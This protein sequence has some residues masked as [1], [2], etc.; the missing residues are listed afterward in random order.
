MDLQNGC[1]Y[2]FHAPK[3]GNIPQPAPFSRML[4]FERSAERAFETPA[5]AAYTHRVPTARASDSSGRLWIEEGDLKTG[6]VATVAPI[7]PIDETYTFRIPPELV[8]RIEAG[9]RLNVPLGKRNRLA[10]AF[11]V[12][13]DEG[14]WDS[15]LKAIDSVVDER[16]FLTPELLALGQWISRYYACPLGRTLSAMVP[17][18]VRKQAGYRD[19]QLVRLT[20]PL[21]EI[22]ATSARIGPKQRAILRRLAEGVEPIDRAHLLADAGASPATL[23]SLQ[24]RAWITIEHQRQ[25]RSAP[26]FDLP[27]R[28][29]EFELNEDQESALVRIKEMIT[30]GPF[31]V[32]LLFGV[33]GSGKTE[34]YIRAMRHVLEAGRQVIML[35]PEIALTTQ[36]VQRLASRFENVAV[37]HSGLTGV[38]RSLTWAAIRSG[39]KRVVIGTRSA[40]FAPCPNLGLIVV[41]EEQDASY[42]NLQAPRFHVR[43]VAIKR[44]QARSI[45][46]ILGS[47]TPSLE[48]WHNCSRRSDYVRIDLPRRVRNLPMPKVTVVDMNDEY[49]E[50]RGFTVLSRL[51]ERRLRETLDRG[52]QAV[53]LMNRRG[54]ANWLFCP[55]CKLRV[56]CPNCNV[57][58][59]VH[60][61]RRQVV[62][63]Y[64]SRREAVPERCPN[65]SCGGTLVQFGTGTQRVEE[66]LRQV[67]PNVRLMRVDSDTMRHEREYRRVVSAFEAREID[68]LVGTQMLAKGL[69]FPFVSFVGVVSADTALAVP[70]F[71][72]GERLFQLVTQVAGRSGRGDVPGEVV[73]QTLSPE[74]PALRAAIRHDYKAFV[75]D[76]LA[77]RRRTR[78]PPFTRLT[79]IV[80]SD[81]RERRVREAAKTLGETIAA[82]LAD[83]APDTGEVLG[84]Q[85]CIL[86]RLR[87]L[88]RYELLIRFPSAPAMQQ[89]LDGLRGRKLLTAKVTSLVIDVDPVSLT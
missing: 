56:R 45:S 86:A 5:G 4:C 65:V 43:D 87:G 85:P 66:R 89:V 68:V 76:E 39:E 84:P 9:Q 44:A 7:A 79:R 30:A 49:Q 70:D 3:V 54:Y 69:D 61:A 41:D 13:I 51:M 12:A 52:Q 20:K 72:A 78:F 73:V 77:M 63:H 8:D 67:F 17:Q 88:Y 28:E 2:P 55:S 47:A 60:A 57:N 18:A 6:P 22:D 64:C 50:R 46:L 35:V 40:V 42:K 37:I 58:M 59:V 23:R 62:C 19:R 80:L 21:D 25:P 38:E 36:M 10:E 33:S 11:C 14:P 83:F 27:R 81:R 82:A 29:P 16:S 1:I 34:V 48:M 71:R 53:V 31:G 15:T 24:E 75:K 26:M 32:T 74:T